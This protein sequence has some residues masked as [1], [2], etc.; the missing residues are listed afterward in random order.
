MTATLSPLDAFRPSFLVRKGN[1]NFRVLPKSSLDF[2]SVLITYSKVHSLRL[3][4]PETVLFGYSVARPTL[5]RSN[6]EGI[7]VLR[8]GLSSPE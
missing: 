5:I 8:E 4:L 3:N 7:V 2:Y 6:S 1:S